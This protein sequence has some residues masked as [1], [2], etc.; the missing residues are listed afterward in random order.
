MMPMMLIFW[1]VNLVLVSAAISSVRATTT[2]N[3]SQ[4]VAVDMI[5]NSP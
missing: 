2:K 5:L 3:S 4:I 1:T